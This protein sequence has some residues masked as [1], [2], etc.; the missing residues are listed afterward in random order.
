ML[1]PI[2]GALI[3]TAIVRSVHGAGAAFA[4]LN[5][6]FAWLNRRRVAATGSVTFQL[7][8]GVNAN[9]LVYA[10]D[11]NVS[12]PDGARVAIQGQPLTGAL[13]AGSSLTYTGYGTAARLSD[14]TTNLAV[15]RN[16]YSTE[17]FFTAGKGF[18]IT[19]AI[20]N[21]QD[22]LA[23]SDGTGNS[24]AFY[25]SNP[26]GSFTRCAAVGAAGSGLGVAG[27]VLNVVGTCYAL[28]C[29]SNGF[30]ASL[31]GQITLLNGAV[32]VAMSNSVNGVQAY[33]A[34]IGNS[35]GLSGAVYARGNAGEG[36]FATLC[37]TIQ[38]SS[39]RCGARQR[40]QRLLRLEHVD[41]PRD[42]LPLLRQRGQRL[43]GGQ[44]ELPRRH[45]HDRHRQRLLRLLRLQRVAAHPP[46]RDRN[47][48]NGPRA[49]P[50]AGSG[51]N[52]DAYMV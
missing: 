8:A 52:N 37:S 46:E 14:T 50:A 28:G 11:I 49:S 2:S 1:S 27:G 19:G 23:T 43:P 36:L 13:P 42:R 6:A 5:Q 12:H 20:G 34:S 26:F 32:A 10:A 51:G 39:G 45:E 35:D 30:S 44:H 9:R 38:V 4:D 24:T 48:G 29:A 21:V 41:D 47:R 15:L 18:K 7:A 31:G 40:F 33:G 16:V 3:D 22:I 25:F 17:I